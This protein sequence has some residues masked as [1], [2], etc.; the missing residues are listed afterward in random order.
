MPRDETVLDAPVTPAPVFAYRAIKSIFFAS[1]DSSPDRNDHNDDNNNNKENIEPGYAKSPL[2]MK[3]APNPNPNPALDDQVLLTPSHKRKWDGAGTLVSPTKGILRTPGLA[4]PR[5]K[6]LKDLN[7][8]FKSVS[9]EA[10]DLGNKTKNQP[11]DVGVAG[12]SVSG[13]AKHG[14]VESSKTVNH[15]GVVSTKKSSTQKQPAAESAPAKVPTSTKANATKTTT[16]TATA[17]E[18]WLST[19]AIE[20]YM[21]Q[22]EKEM[23]RL[24]RYGQKMR[25][26]ARQKDAENEELMGMIR[27]LRIENEKLK[28]GVGAKERGSHPLN[29]KHGGAE[30]ADA[31]ADAGLGRGYVREEV[32]RVEDTARGH[33]TRSVTV[34]QRRSF[35]G[36]AK[37]ADRRMKGLA[38]AVDE[39]V[40]GGKLNTHADATG[41]HPC[42][43]SAKHKPGS[44]VSAASAN[45]RTAPLTAQQ[46]SN[47]LSIS[48][49]RDHD[50][51]H[52]LD[53]QISH[54][55][56]DALVAATATSMSMSTNPAT[57]TATDTDHGA[58]DHWART[59]PGT[60]IVTGTLSAAGLSVGAGSVR[61]PPDRLAAARERLRRRTEARKASG[62]GGGGGGADGIENGP[63]PI[64]PGEKI[65]ASDH[66]RPRNPVN[67]HGV[68]E[69][70]AHS[71]D[72]SQV[73]WL[74]L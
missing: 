54:S 27:Q 46:S 42:S 22:T 18:G 7:V 73:D 28:Q 9:P 58:K 40:G 31:D 30:H 59:R 4:T 32:D 68:L 55:K 16:M 13:H 2:K 62:G 8:K 24:V 25:E 33:H 74:D 44:H 47:H 34:L 14:G 71:R 63:G 36:D 38:S 11:T 65:G 3:M 6:L 20:A 50:H 52:D 39:T 41:Y 60:S 66:M 48:R 56:G 57:G 21:L 35:P 10:M 49:T 43:T 67:G 29:S 37:D 69:T 1:P 5:A 23:K 61:L 17:T 19:Q 12:R 15:V 45:H 26:Y 53:R 51:D 70:D 72:Q 64:D